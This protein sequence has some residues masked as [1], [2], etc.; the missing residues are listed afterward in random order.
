MRTDTFLMTGSL[1][2]L[3][4]SAPVLAANPPAHNF[5]TEARAEYVFGCMQKLGGQNYDNL[6]KCSCSIDRIADQVSYD[7]YLA[8]E[9]F[10]RG[11]GAGG[12]RLELI[13]EGS[14]ANEYR[15]KFE[16]VNGIAAKHCMIDSVVDNGR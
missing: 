5:P 7:D 4:L 15:R 1:V 2:T 10:E 16:K 11:R 6:Y 12:E 8:M 13:R 3:L 14:M 9:T